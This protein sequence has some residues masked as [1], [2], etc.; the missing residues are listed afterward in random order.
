MIL[1]DEAVHGPARD[2]HVVT[3]RLP[4]TATT[5]TFASHSCYSN[6]WQ[7]WST[8]IGAT[9]PVILLQVRVFSTTGITYDGLIQPHLG[10]L[11]R[12]WSRTLDR[13]RRRAILLT[14]HAS[15]SRWPRV[16]SRGSHGTL[17]RTRRDARKISTMKEKD[18]RATRL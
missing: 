11:A 8:A 5:F 15:Y 7:G 18:V 17:L 10:H 6:V 16:I 12:V 14:R 4:G 3:P 2:D 1:Y 13:N 9:Q